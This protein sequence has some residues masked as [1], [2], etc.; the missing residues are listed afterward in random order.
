MSANKYFAHDRQHRH[1]NPTT[2]QL[3]QRRFR[4][5]SQITISLYP[6]KI[7]SGRR[8]WLRGCSRFAEHV[9]FRLAYANND[10]VKTRLH[11]IYI[12]LKGSPWLS[13][14]NGQI[15]LEFN[16]KHIRLS[17]MLAL[18]VTRMPCALLS[19]ET[20]LRTTV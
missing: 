3:M 9:V 20:S 19:I 8:S 7:P 13:P 1:P 4:R 16:V 17:K 2:V 5:Y 12:I 10:N 6:H 15:S 11:L 18:G 14:I